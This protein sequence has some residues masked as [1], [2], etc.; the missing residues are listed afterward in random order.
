MDVRTNPGSDA[1]HPVSASLDADKLMDDLFFDVDRM[2]VGGANVQ[3]LEEQPLAKAEPAIALQPLVVPPIQLPESIIPAPEKP[4]ETAA[5]AP[6]VNY[7]DR[8]LWGVAL[9]SVGASVVLWLV[10]QDILKLPF[11]AATPSPTVSPEPLASAD[12]QFIGYMRRSL[13]NIERRSPNTPAT[14]PGV[15]R[16]NLPPSPTTAPPTVL[17]RIYIPVFPPQTLASPLIPLPSRSPSPTTPTPANRSP[18]QAP[19]TT[20]NRPAEPESRPRAETE[21]RPRAERPAE[22]EPRRAEPE[23][24]TTARATVNR[25][26]IGVL[27]LGD[28]SSALFD[29]EGNTQR[30]ALGETIANTGWTLVKIENQQAVIR[31]GSEVRSLYIGQRF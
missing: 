22:P 28:N 1:R 25:S 23:E 4:P 13:N 6:S 5:P 24:P 18:S 11:L 9:A 31:R 30:V 27:E 12:A 16:A 20:A 26:L 3:E 8:L 17:E 2:I 19:A 15:N 14:T 21:S 10:S 7:L 29:L